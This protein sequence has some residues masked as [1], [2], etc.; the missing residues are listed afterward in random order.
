MLIFD[1]Q[2]KFGFFKFEN[3]TFVFYFKFCV[4]FSLGVWTA[5][6]AG[7]GAGVDSYFEYL[8]KGGLLFQRPLLLHQF[9]GIFLF[10]IS[11]LVFSL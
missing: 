10:F 2:S 5:V 3:C 8:A 9:Y 4:A 6:D 7:I 11:C 1:F